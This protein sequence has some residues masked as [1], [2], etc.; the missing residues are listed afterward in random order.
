VI[1]H[2]NMTSEGEGLCDFRFEADLYY[3]DYVIQF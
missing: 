3:H 2:V 1:V